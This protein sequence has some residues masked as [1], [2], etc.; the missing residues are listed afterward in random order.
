M[1]QGY[2]GDFEY[3]AGEL[4]NFMR[5]NDPTYNVLEMLDKYVPDK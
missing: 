1:G 5:S 3:L 2:L 4:L